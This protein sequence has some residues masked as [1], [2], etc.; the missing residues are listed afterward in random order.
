MVA[1]SLLQAQEV[2]TLGVQEGGRHEMFGAVVDVEVDGSG[3]AFILDTSYGEV[4]V[5]S[6]SNEFL[7]SIGRPGKGPSEFLAPERLALDS[8][9]RL[10]V[11]DRH[12]GIKVFEET[13]GA[14]ALIASIPLQ[15]EPKGICC[16]SGSV[17]IQG[18]TEADNGVLYRYG[19]ASG[20]SLLAFGA[21]YKSGN[22]LV[23]YYLT[24]GEVACTPKNVVYLP[25]LIP[26]LYAFTHE[27]EPVWASRF[28]PFQGAR[29]EEESDGSG[30]GAVT[31]DVFSSPHEQIVGAEPVDENH[32]LVQ[33][34]LFTPESLRSSDSGERYAAIRTFLV[35]ALSGRAIFVSSDLPKILAFGQRQFYASRSSP[36]PQIAIFEMADHALPAS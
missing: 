2:T 7:Y 1:N 25:R 4:R 12:F 16:S 6:P 26:M 21:S 11:S 32:I 18:M 27:G 13:N 9:G 29:V 5:Y 17:F 34:A 28:S 36:F 30:E 35:S 3:R 24:P 8:A 22:Y 23:R 19:S 15:F 14:H 33:I 31:M 20:D 10:F